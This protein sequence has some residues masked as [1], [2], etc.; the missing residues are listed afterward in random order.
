MVRSGHAWPRQVTTV[1]GAVEV[2]APRVNDRRADPGEQSYWDGLKLRPET[3]T[4]VTLTS[5]VMTHGSY[6]LRRQG[7]PQT[8]GMV[9]P[10]SRHHVSCQFIQC[11][12][13]WPS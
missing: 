5:F 4:T 1:A 11:P 13:A 12:A 8:H 9:C 7:Q 10:C 3:L 2:R 6:P